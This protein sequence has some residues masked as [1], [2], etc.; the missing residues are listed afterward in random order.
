MFL[1]LED[2]HAIIDSQELSHLAPTDAIRLKAEKMAIQKIKKQISRQ[3][4]AEAVFS[5]IGDERDDTIVEYTIYYVLYI[6]YNRI[7]KVKVPD[8]RFEQ[9]T[10][11]RAF[12]ENI[13]KDEIDADLPRKTPPEQQDSP[14]I[15]FGS[16]PKRK[17]HKF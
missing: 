5:A 15:R 14:I 17:S 16:N 4:D 12:F 11:A 7:A 8:D 3:Y 2:Y 6:L 13:R 10:E 1:T 9:Y